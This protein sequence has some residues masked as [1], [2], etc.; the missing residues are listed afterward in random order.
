MRARL[1]LL[2]LSAFLTPADPDLKLFDLP[3]GFKI[4]DRRDTVPP[5]FN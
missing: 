5:Q 1:A 2:V 4:D 3:D